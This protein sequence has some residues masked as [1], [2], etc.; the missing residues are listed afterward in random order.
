MFTYVIIGV[1]A[2]SHSNT[3]YVSS[4]W[5]SAIYNKHNTTVYIFTV[6]YLV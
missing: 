1:L 5:F 2:K 6:I 4:S 3:N